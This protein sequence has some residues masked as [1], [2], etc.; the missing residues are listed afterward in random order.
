MRVQ[1]LL[2]MWSLLL[3]CLQLLKKV[4]SG[5]AQWELRRARDLPCTHSLD[6]LKIQDSLKHRLELH[7]VNFW[8]SPAESVM[9]IK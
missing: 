3:R 7:Y 8:N 5:L 6:M 4:R 2:I 9:E 1:Q